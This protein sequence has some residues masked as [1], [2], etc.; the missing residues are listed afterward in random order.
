MS[1]S[2]SARRQHHVPRFYLKRFA[3][4][5][6]LVAYDRA[7]ENS[8]QFISV[9]KAAQSPGFYDVP[10]RNGP[11]DGVEQA[12]SQV[13][14]LSGS[15]VKSLIEDGVRSLAPSDRY[16]MAIFMAMQI[17]RGP[18]LTDNFFAATREFE[19]LR[20]AATTDG[21]KAQVAALLAISVD[22]LPEPTE[23]RIFPDPADAPPEWFMRAAAV[24]L[25]AE[26]IAEWLFVRRWASLDLG[27]AGLIT[28]DRPVV[29]YRV[30]NNDGE[31]TGIGN[32]DLV[33]MPLSRRV[34]LLVAN[35]DF[36]FESLG[37]HA[38][39]GEVFNKI[40]AVSSHRWV[41]HHPDDALPA[42]LKLPDRNPPAHSD[43]PTMHREGDAVRIRSR[44]R[45]NLPTPPPGWVP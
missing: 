29:F 4:R 20:A 25:L 7:A 10:T 6:R 42:D 17:V 28:S 16:R 43:A 27:A 41:F 18:D 24:G 15:I 21:V 35:D 8:R 11:S 34:A 40:V 12:L 5:G 19:S 36:D 33:I 22:D 39:V 30:G 13:E 32:A 45:W 44:V 14:S 2:P 31:P 23:D 26:P 37:N 9:K 38:N 1:G 3:D